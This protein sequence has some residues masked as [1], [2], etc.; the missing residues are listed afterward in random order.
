MTEE[1]RRSISVVKEQY[2]KSEALEGYCPHELH[3]VMHAGKLGKSYSINTV[4]EHYG[5]GSYT[6]YRKRFPEIEFDV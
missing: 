4:S 6:L 1:D 5:I 2:Q 3:R